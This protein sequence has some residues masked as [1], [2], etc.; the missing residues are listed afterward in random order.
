MDPGVRSAILIAGLVF[1]IMFGG[2]TLVVMA[3]DGFTIL[4]FFSILIVVL[5]GIALWGAINSTD[6]RRR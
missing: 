2:M 5:L 3:N 6:D 4:V 1:V